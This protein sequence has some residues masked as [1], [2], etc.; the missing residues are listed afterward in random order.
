MAVAVAVALAVLVDGGEGGGSCDH[1]AMAVLSRRAVVRAVARAVA[2][3]VVR[4]MVGGS[5]FLTDY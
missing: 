4:A 1:G 3:V 5:S 2:R